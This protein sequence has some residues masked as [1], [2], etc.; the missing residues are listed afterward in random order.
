MDFTSY[1]VS[2]LQRCGADILVPETNSYIDKICCAGH[3][4]NTEY[5]GLLAQQEL[6][7]GVIVAYMIA[8]PYQMAYD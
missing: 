5:F 2:L 6:I 7:G 1:R 8:S 4:Q 3:F